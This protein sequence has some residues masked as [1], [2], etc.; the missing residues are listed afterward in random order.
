MNA[1]QVKEL[2]KN[3]LV[4]RQER[5]PRLQSGDEI[6]RYFAGLPDG[7]EG[8][9]VDS[10]GPLIVLTVYNPIWVP[11][12][13][14]LLDVL[15]E[16][17]TPDRRVIGKVR[18]SS[19]GFDYLDP[20]AALGGHWIAREDDCFFEVRADTKNDFGLFP[21]ARPA[22]IAL[23]NL[24][25]QKSRVLN[26]FSY[27][28]GFAVVACRA[29]ALSAANVDANA[30][31]LTWGKRNATLNKVDFAVIPELA[32]KYLSRLERRVA[33]GKAE[34]P[35]VW[36]C[37]PPAFGVGRGQTRVLKYFWDDFWK[38]VESLRPRAVL[39]LRNDRTG[40]RQGDTLASDLR[41]RIGSLYDQQPVSFAQSPSLC[42]EG[43]D[44]FYKLNE[45]L[46]LMRR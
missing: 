12:A 35:D 3:A 43:S 44:A 45:S 18:S 42:Y 9:L 32:Q 17:L 27:T 10:F 20:S 37:D 39:V 19:G 21:D 26:L 40:Y 24:I 16:C 8:V 28:C 30:E 2:F 6:G 14:F 46:V 7:I 29:G 23:R 25:D 1:Q 33:E 4:Q 31:M 41:G 38:S 15:R 34:C 5:E 36:V 11:R 13:A 22:R